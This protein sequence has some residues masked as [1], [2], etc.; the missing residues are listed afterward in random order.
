M[1]PV[2][3]FAVQVAFTPEAET[4][5]RELL[6]AVRGSDHE[7]QERLLAALEKLESITEGVH[8]GD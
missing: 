5:L 6:V 8:N 7:T 1:A 3:A 4:L 2:P